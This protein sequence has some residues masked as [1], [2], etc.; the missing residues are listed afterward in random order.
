MSIDNR[1]K[2]VLNANGQ[3][4]SYDNYISNLHQQIDDHLQQNLKLAYENS[5]LKEL[6]KQWK[7]LQ[8]EDW[9]LMRQT[10][11]N[12]IE[13][14]RDHNASLTTQCADL[15]ADKS[16]LQ[17]QLEELKANCAELKKKRFYDLL[18]NRKK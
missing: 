9:A 10:L 12:I 13:D 16:N 8:F 15:D 11:L 17:G 3:M 6:E 14:L 2:Y 1:L 7:E 5:R 18:F 4:M